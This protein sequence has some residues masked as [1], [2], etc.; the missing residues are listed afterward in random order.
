MVEVMGTPPGTA[1]Q[2]ALDVQV[3][4]ETDCGDHLRRLITFSSE[5]GGRTPAWL[6][7]PKSASAI[8]PVPGVLCLHP[9]NAEIGHDVIVGLGGKANR[10]YA[11]ELA[12]RGYVTIA[13]SYPLLAKY[14]PE[15]K[16]LGYSSGT[17][18]AIRDNIRA[19][20]VLDSLPIVAPGRYGAIGHSLGGHNSIFTAVFDDRI[21][22][23]VTSCGFDSFS[24]YFRGDPKF[25]RAGEG[26][27][28]ER[29]MP[30]LAGYAG[31]LDEIPFDFHELIAALAPRAV[32]ISAPQHDSNFRADS[33][34]RIVS[35]ARP[36]FDLLGKRD[37]LEVAYP[38]C[39][40]DFPVEMRER[41]YAIFD[42]HLKAKPA[43]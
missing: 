10:G 33:V 18:K 26:W 43:R 16:A 2:G 30:R 7:V 22:V 40:H 23:V 3:E 21:A 27:C 41:A 15:L 35:A 9:T 29:Y 5:P 13:P 37:R 6:L 8:T 32:F 34:A 24:D 14:Q 42:R 25:W 1:K 12:Q 28:Q 17:M 36:V 31:R 38:D 11:L 4:S 19:L 20:D 39:D